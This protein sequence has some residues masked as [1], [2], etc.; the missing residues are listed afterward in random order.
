MAPRKEPPD[1]A[2]AA[3]ALA[4]PEAT[5]DHPW[6]ERAFKVRSKVFLFLS[7]HDGRLSLSVKLP[8]GHVEALLLP[9]TEPTGYGLGKHRWVTARFADDALVPLS[10][11]RAWIDE[12][13]RAVAPKRLAAGLP[14][15]SGTSSSTP[16]EPP[17]APARS[18]RKKA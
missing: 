11:V 4:Y 9:F 5:E 13:Y 12:S 8:E 2:L 14:D 15:S 7:R 10:V 1:E 16:S 17:R 18:R 3:C 6:G